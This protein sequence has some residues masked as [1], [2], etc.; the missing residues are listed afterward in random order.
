[1]CDNEQQAIERLGC[2]ALD[3]DNVKYLIIHCSA[4]REDQDYTELELCKDH[5][6]R[7]F[8]K[9]GYHYYVRK[10]GALTQFREL[11]EVGAHCKPYNR[12]SIGICYE[13]GICSDGITEGNTMTKQQ[14]QVIGGLLVQLQ[15]QFPNAVIRG[16]RDMPLATKKACP[17]FNAKQ[18]FKDFI[19]NEDV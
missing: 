9:V 8:L 5:A 14:Y 18:I 2:E 16:H 11:D 12:C 3:P 15:N 4:T 19:I 17:C 13:G 10:S 6:K 7:K 1:M